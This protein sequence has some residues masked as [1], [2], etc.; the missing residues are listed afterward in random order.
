M[1]KV[2]CATCLFLILQIGAWA[3]PGDLEGP[4]KPPIEPG[5]RVQGYALNQSRAL[6]LT[7]FFA[8]LP[9]SPKVSVYAGP[10]LLL[11]NAGSARIET[12]SLGLTGGRA[13]FRIFPF[14]GR[15]RY[16]LGLHFHFAQFLK[17]DFMNNP[18]DR[19]L[20]HTAL[21]MSHGLQYD[22][23]NRIFFLADA[24]VGRLKWGD[25][26]RGELGFGFSAGCGLR[27]W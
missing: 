23:F 17:V 22:L 24:E 11:S 10:E 3:Q 13:G 25:R 8:Q 2:F 20:P 12:R 18:R 19:Y 6:Y 5:L 9:L 4:R 7:Q 15:L 1:Q 21:L 16:N 26:N 27:I 14:S